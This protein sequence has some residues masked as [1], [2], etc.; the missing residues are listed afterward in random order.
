MHNDL[1]ALIALNAIEGLGPRRIWQLLQTF[2]TASAAF[3]APDSAVRAL[4]GFGSLLLSRLKHGPDDAFVAEQLQAAEKCNGRILPF[5]DPDY[6]ECLKTIYDPPVLLHVRGEMRYGPSPFFGVVGTRQPTPYGRRACRSIVTGLAAQGVTVVSGLALGVDGVAHQ[7]ALD[8]GGRTVAVLG[9]GADLCHP[10]SHWRLYDAI[11]QHGAVVSE[12]PFG[13]PPEPGHFPRRNRIISGLSQGVLVI[14]AGEK[15]GALITSDYA[16]DQSR[17]VFALPGNIDSMQ[18]AGTN[19]LL[20]QGAYPALSAADILL[21]LGRAAA[22]KAVPT[23]PDLP[24]GEA[25]LFGLLS[26]T[27]RHIDELAR[28]SRMALPELHPLLFALELKGVA[29]QTSGM[30][31]VRT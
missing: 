20:Q 9:C 22:P 5:T 12:F 10:P 7:A 23:P 15:S 17:E 2:G 26:S 6:P 24:A 1:E 18:S 13:T 28:E 11:L 31:Y 25:R 3:K 14:E 19:R 4:D 29:A 27:P 8:A 30:R 16:L 21:R